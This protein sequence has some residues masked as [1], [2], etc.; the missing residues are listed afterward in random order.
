MMKNALMTIRAISIIVMLFCVALTVGSMAYESGCVFA[1]AVA[2]TLLVTVLVSI[3][4]WFY[5]KGKE[6]SE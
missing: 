6:E 4:E 5:D 3:A 2:V 1:I